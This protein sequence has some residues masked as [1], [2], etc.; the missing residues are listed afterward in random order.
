MKKNNNDFDDV[1]KTEQIMSQQ[2]NSRRTFIKKAVYVAPTLIALGAL[3]RPTETKALPGPPPSGP[4]DVD[5]W[6]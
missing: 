1:Q 5:S 2:N 6:Q 3:T 4:Q